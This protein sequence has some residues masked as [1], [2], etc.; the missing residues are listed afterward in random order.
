MAQRS[1]PLAGRRRF[2]LLRGIGK[3]GKVGHSAF[4]RTRRH[5]PRHKAHAVTSK[6]W[7][8]AVGWVKPALFMALP[9][10][11]WA[12]TVAGGLG[13]VFAAG[14][15]QTNPINSVSEQALGNTLLGA[16]QSSESRD[17]AAVQLAALR[18]EGAVTILVQAL[19]ST[20]A[21][22]STAAARALAQANWPDSRFITPL[23]GLLGNSQ[24][25][26][27]YAAQA[28]SQYDQNPSATSIAS[29]LL[30][31]AY[32]GQYPA[33]A[34]APVI[35]A[36]GAFAYKDT[37][38]ALIGILQDPD[39]SDE[40][41]QAA[42]VALAEMTGLSNLGQ[43]A[44][45]WQQWWQG[46][47]DMDSGAFTVRMQQQRGAHFAEVIGDSDRLG[48]SLDKLLKSLYFVSAPG[49]QPHI[50][51]SY[52]GSEAP[53]VRRI[54]AQIVEIDVG[55]GRPM[56]E[57]ARSSL[58]NLVA[59]DASGQ[60]RAAAAAALGLD[61]TAASILVRRLGEETDADALVAILNALAV[62]QDPQVIRQ[63]ALML[64]HPSIPVAQAAA[65]L[66]ANDG[67]TLRDPKQADLEQQ[68]EGQLQ[69][70]LDRTNSPRFQAL[71]R[72]ITAA[73]ASLGDMNLYD[74]FIQLSS[75][76]EPDAVRVE[77]IG[78][79]GLLAQ[80]N[81]DIAAVLADFVDTPQ[82]P[83][84]LRL[85]AVQML[86]GVPTTAYVDRLVDRLNRTPE[87]ALE[88][89][90][91]IWQTV[92]AWFAQMN[93]ERLERLAERLRNERDYAHEADV[94]RYYVQ[95]LEARKTDD[96][97]QMAA[98]QRET[99]ATRE[100]ENLNMPAQAAA[101]FAGVVAYYQAHAKT[102]DDLPHNPFRAEAAALLAAGPPY[103][104]AI[105]FAADTLADPKR[106]GVLPDV[107]EQF[108][109][110]ANTLATADPSDQAAMKNALELVQSFNDAKLKIPPS[111]SYV[112]DNLQSAADQARQNLANLTPAA[113][114]P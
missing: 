91:A 37:A 56:T 12:A 104:A 63:A 14:T 17:G 46:V 58:L 25:V 68:I 43:D 70:A 77:A 79:L 9:G 85:K 2:Y 80:S 8:K 7:I 72:S 3:Y 59:T 45:Q 106:A 93:D 16:G 88:V 84:A 33:P 97:L 50:L 20:D 54:G 18:S 114:Q 31:A 98:S 87:P 90:L 64:N 113:S 53:E 94:R 19:Q 86:A 74:R 1:A 96:A 105:K 89:R 29:R 21:E 49:E 76:A 23:E 41:R 40:L 107:L 62:R 51:D 27:T 26:N 4:S 82:T 112:S 67:A 81:H 102:G 24:T 28:L 39:Q 101:D 103:T 100:L 35:R 10:V 109:R 69:A 47:K 15:G 5:H 71:R 83:T 36:M 38:A 57:A 42:S 30:A 34:R 66:I 32:D 61:P 6:R 108:P 111:L 48:R 95:Q 52:L 110:Y 75:A 55:G 13:R 11:I 99:I 65:D 92:E 44:G 60:V 78:G 22:I 73:L